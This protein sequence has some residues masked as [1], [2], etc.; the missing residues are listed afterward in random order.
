MSP[1]LFSIL[2]PRSITLF[3]FILVVLFLGATFNVQVGPESFVESANAKTD[4]KTEEKKG[5]KTT[6]N[7]VIQ[8]A[9]NSIPSIQSEIQS[10]M[11]SMSGSSKPMA[12]TRPASTK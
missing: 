4:A 9:G 11:E 5:G 6:L 10:A 1:S 2:S 7:P 8:S 12:T 3:V